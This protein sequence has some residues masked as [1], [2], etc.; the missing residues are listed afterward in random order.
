[1]LIASNR[2]RKSF[3]LRFPSSFM[4]A[5]V[6]DEG[7]YLVEKDDNADFAVIDAYGVL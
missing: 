2:K 3:G 4:E 5:K 7:G 6:V 1:M